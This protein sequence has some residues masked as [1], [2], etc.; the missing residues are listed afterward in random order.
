MTKTRDISKILQGVTV[1]GNIIADQ[2]IGS[3]LVVTTA[4]ITGTATM[5]TANP[6]FMRITGTDNTGYAQFS[7]GSSS[8]P[9]T[10]GTHMIN[11]AAG[12]FQI[13]TGN[14]SQES[15]QKQLE[16][17]TSG[18]MDVTGNLTM[19]GNDVLAVIAESLTNSGY[20][21]L[22]NGLIIQWGRAVL[23]SLGAQSITWPKA[24]VS[25]PFIAFGNEVSDPNASDNISGG[26]QSATGWTNIDPVSAGTYHWIAIGV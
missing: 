19:S 21:E 26:T 14:P 20:V 13:K 3:N 6:E 24:F 7:F 5:D 17:D 25:T 1:D 11:T 4:N 10:T 16:I 18:N 9:S 8:S 12:L 2:Y 23:T 15:A 22:S